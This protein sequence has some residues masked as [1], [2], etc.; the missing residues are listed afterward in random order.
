MISGTAK[1]QKCYPVH[2]VAEKLSTTVKDITLPCIDRLRYYLFF[3]WSLVMTRKHFAIN[4]FLLR[5]L[6]VMEIWHLSNSSS[7]NCMEQASSIVR[8]TQ[9][10]LRNV[11]SYQKFPGTPCFAFKP[12]GK[13][14][15]AG[16]SGRNACIVS[17]QHNG[18]VKRVWL[19]TCLDEAASL[20]SWLSPTS[21]LWL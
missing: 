15:I 11:T 2:W 3:Q 18:L 8:Q 12:P 6:V 4:R 14:L 9:E 5:V 20:F 13:N 17:Y 1:N 16:R 7:A 10:R 19:S 21:D